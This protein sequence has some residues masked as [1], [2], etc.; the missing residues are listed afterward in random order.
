MNGLS[1]DRAGVPVPGRPCGR[2]NRD[3]CSLPVRP[4]SWPLWEL[5]LSGVP[6]LGSQFKLSLDQYHHNIIL[7]MIISAIITINRPPGGRRGHW[8]R[9]LNMKPEV[10]VQLPSPSHW[11]VQFDPWHRVSWSLASPSRRRVTGTRRLGVTDD[12]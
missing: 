5:R 8:Q 11:Q 12:S 9:D 3:L 2:Y 1:L 7:I 6:V 10:R 4:G